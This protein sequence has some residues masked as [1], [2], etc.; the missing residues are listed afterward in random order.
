MT[1]AATS[2]DQELQDADAQRERARGAERLQQRDGVEMPLHVTPRG[3]RHGN[4]AQQNA[5]EARKTQEAARAIDGVLDL[6]ARL[7]DVEQ[8]LAALLVRAEPGLE[9][10]D[11]RAVACEQQPL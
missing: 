10:I 2:D 9:F 8:P 1:V 4:G 3:H 5:D 11:A 7:R 6:R